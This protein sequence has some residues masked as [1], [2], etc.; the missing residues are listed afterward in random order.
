M[1]LGPD[2]N[3]IIGIFKHSIK[4]TSHVILLRG[5]QI[6]WLS[7]LGEVKMTKILILANSESLKREAKVGV[8][9]QHV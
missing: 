7:S 1:F 2:G 3:V 9:F 4:I 5:K 6:C 8:R